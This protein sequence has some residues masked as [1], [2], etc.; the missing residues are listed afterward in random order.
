M[1][2]RD[3]AE[4]LL[5]LAA[6]HAPKLYA[7]GIRGRVT[8]G[9]LSFEVVEDADAEVE[10]EATPEPIS[11]PLDDPETFGYRPGTQAPSRKAKK[12]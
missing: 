11:D 10:N 9:E 4:A 6:E 2:T 3:Q 12:Q 7:A 5:E 1:V 8:V